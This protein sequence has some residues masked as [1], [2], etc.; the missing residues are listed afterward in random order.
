LESGLVFLTG[1]RIR[2]AFSKNGTGPG[3]GFPSIY[4]WNQNCS[5]FWVKGFLRPELFYFLGFRVLLRNR[6][7]GS[8]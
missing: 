7:K 5:I 1:T 8:L 4:V 6:T 2:T 3:T